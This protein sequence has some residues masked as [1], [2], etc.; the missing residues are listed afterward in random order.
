MHA[1]KVSKVVASHS[2]LENP[3][4]CYYFRKDGLNAIHKDVV[5]AIKDIK[6]KCVIEE[7]D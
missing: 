3:T 5:C 4:T 6:D 1:C 7:K 2:K